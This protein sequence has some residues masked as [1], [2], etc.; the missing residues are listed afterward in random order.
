MRRNPFHSFAA[1]RYRLRTN[2]SACSEK[3]RSRP[4]DSIATNSGLTT[5]DIARNDPLPLGIALLKN[6]QAS[7]G[8]TAP[9]AEAFALAVQCTTTNWRA[10]M[11]PPRYP[12]RSIP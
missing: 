4:S 7:N 1:K 8:V 9:F 12:P 10:C 2:L 11:K 3:T 5:W 6:G